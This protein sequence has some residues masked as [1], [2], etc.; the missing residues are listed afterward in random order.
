MSGLPNPFTQTAATHTGSDQEPVQVDNFHED[1]RGLDL[2]VQA[3]EMVENRQVG[4]IFPLLFML[5]Y[6]RSMRFKL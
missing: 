5:V 1:R 3:A 6:L 2:L 4:L